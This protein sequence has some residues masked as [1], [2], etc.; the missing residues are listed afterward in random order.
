ME[1]NLEFKPP[2]PVL[3]EENPWAD[4][5]LDRLEFAERLTELIQL[6]TESFVIGL[7]GDW[8]TGKTF[9]LKRWKA[10]LE[11]SGIKVIY[12]N[13]WEEDF[14]DDP[15]TALL[16]KISSLTDS[17]KHQE[18]G[19]SIKRVAVPL[20]SNTIKGLLKH[21]TGISFEGWENGTFKRYSEQIKSRRE[22]KKKLGEISDLLK[23][24]NGQPLVFI[25]DELDRCRPSFAIE[26][27][28]RVKHIFDIRGIV[29]V[30]GVNRRELCSSVRSIY[31]DIRSD[32]YIRRFFDMELALPDVGREKFVHCAI[33]RHGLVDFFQDLGGKS[34]SV[35]HRDEFKEFSGLF[36]QLSEI[37]NLSFRDIEFCLRTMSLVGKNLT[38]SN[39]MYPYLIGILLPLRL[40]NEI[41]YKGLL[42]GKQVAS[43]VV[44]YI[45]SMEPTKSD[46]DRS[47]RDR[48]LDLM[49]AYLYFVAGG[50]LHEVKNQL[51]SIANGKDPSN[52]KLLSMRSRN[53]GKEH[54][55]EM[56][57]LVDLVERKLASF[58][59]PGRTV[60]Y[61]RGLLEVIQPPEQ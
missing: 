57:D 37:L 52:P 61:I 23:D 50:N 56:F 16:G 27:L 33:D 35:I 22:L 42:E 3:S 10:Y 19:E 46:E 40:K 1:K 26:L 55:V 5:A 21:H 60:R 14:I 4:D 41:L 47:R 8:G 43:E 54:A 39:F 32:V 17:S 2:E 30:F 9:F 58:G 29:F 7:D 24:E 53:S 11:K 36:A 49:E 15:L 28:E 48:S 59:S 44:D 45:T 18:L 38:A 34:E 51:R 12:Y 13:A 6:P 31:G 25:V 20:I